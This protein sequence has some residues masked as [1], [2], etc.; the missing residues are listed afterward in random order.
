MLQKLCSQMQFIQWKQLQ[1]N[2]VGPSPSSAL[3][4]FLR[5]RLHASNMPPRGHYGHS[6]VGVENFHSTLPAP[7]SSYLP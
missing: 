5:V 3:G 4:L 6:P 7:N 1:E 2:T